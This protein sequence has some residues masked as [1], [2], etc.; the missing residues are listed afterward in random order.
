M[1]PIMRVSI[2]VPLY[3]TEKDISACLDSILAQTY[4]H[5]EVIIVNDASTDNSRAI[6]SS[7]IEKNSSQCEIIVMDHESNKGASAARNTGID[8]ATGEYIL[9]LDSDDRLMPTCVECLTRPLK[10]KRYDVVMGDYLQMG[11][12]PQKWKL[13]I[14]GGEWNDP[15]SIV[16]NHCHQNIYVFPFNKLCKKSFI[17]SNNLYFEE[18]VTHEDAL[19]SLRLCLCMESMYVVEDVT[20]LYTIRTDSVTG[21][22]LWCDEVLAYVHILPLMVKAFNECPNKVEASVKYHFFDDILIRYHF[23]FYDRLFEEYRQLRK[24]D[25]RPASW[26]LRK[27]LKSYSYMR[28]N[29]HRLL[30]L[31]A[32]ALVYFKLRD[33][34]YEDARKSRR[35]IYSQPTGYPT[36][37]LTT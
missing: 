37:N 5:I 21:S 8:A 10:D 7:Y 33:R 35:S 20:Y 11:Y 29:F 28:A 30:P 31:Q 13:K 6:V 27:S 2:I 18:G 24:S 25:P 22:E 19:W 4:P 15:K 3:N 17:Q 23:C 26:I 12:R 16:T 36:M 9:F 34:L 32:V 14:G 1:C